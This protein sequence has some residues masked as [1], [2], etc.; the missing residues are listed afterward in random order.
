ML[1]E[2]KSK[3][4]HALQQAWLTAVADVPLSRSQVRQ[5]RVCGVSEQ[6]NTQ[7]HSAVSALQ[8]ELTDSRLRG[9]NIFKTS[10]FGKKKKN[11]TQTQNTH[12]MFQ[13]IAINN[14][15]TSQLLP[16]LL[17]PRCY[18]KRESGGISRLQRREPDVLCSCWQLQAVQGRR[19]VFCGVQAICAIWPRTRGQLLQVVK[20]M[21]CE[22]CILCKQEQNS[23]SLNMKILCIDSLSFSAAILP[24]CCNMFALYI[25]KG[26]IIGS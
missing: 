10:L 8:A 23:V 15:K 1:S 12:V 4:T 2:Q 5:W 19:S 20:N 22:N 25:S 6:V 17:S 7:A 3:W 21:R 13:S 14:L 11:T 18:G 26:C 16:N 9:P 24:H